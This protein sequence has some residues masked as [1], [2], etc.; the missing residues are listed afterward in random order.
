MTVN[1]HV[2]YW[3]TTLLR[4]VRPGR[5]FLTASFT[6]EHC[7]GG[8]GTTIPQQRGWQSRPARRNPTIKNLPAFF[9]LKNTTRVV[10]FAKVTKTDFP[11]KL[12]RATVKPAFV[13]TI[14][15]GFG[16][17][18]CARGCDKKITN[19]KRVVTISSLRTFSIIGH[20][21]YAIPADMGRG[22][23]ARVRVG[24]LQN[25]SL[26]RASRFSARLDAKNLWPHFQFRN[27]AQNRNLFRSETRRGTRV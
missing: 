22:M 3:V 20:C 24:T 27:F 4:L 11:L 13:R 12:G 19:N 9:F 2:P 6:G 26:H 5:L 25:V 8:T 16:R 10:I 7:P 17:G 15:T 14:G 23:L 1:L 21:G 18:P